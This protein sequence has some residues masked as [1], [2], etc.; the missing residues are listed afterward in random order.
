MLAIFE[1]FFSS[2]STQVHMAAN[3]GPKSTIISHYVHATECRKGYRGISGSHGRPK[4]DQSRI[5]YLIWPSIA[6]SATNSVHPAG[7]SAEKS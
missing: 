2:N 6:P 7:Y 1:S 5:D 4:D 3:V